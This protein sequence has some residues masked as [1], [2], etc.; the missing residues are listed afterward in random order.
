MASCVGRHDHWGGMTMRAR[1]QGANGVAAVKTA[2]G[3]FI[4][5]HDD[6]STDEQCMELTLRCAAQA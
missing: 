6:K 4:L 1:Y 5:G 3:V 2:N